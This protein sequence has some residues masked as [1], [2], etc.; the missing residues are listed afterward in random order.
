M[1]KQFDYIVVGQGIAG[2]LLSYELMRAG[3]QVLVYDL[4]QVHTPSR[5]AAGIINPISGRRFELAWKYPECYAQLEETYANL[6]SLLGQQLFFA[7][8]LYNVFPSQQMR[9]AF[10]EAST[11][12]PYMHLPT[13][14]AFSEVLHQPFGVGCVQGGNV[15]LDRL[16]Q[17]WRSK[18]ELSES[19]FDASKLEFDDLGVVYEAVR[20]RAVLFC[21]GVPMD[22]NPWFHALRFLPNK[23]EIFKI[24]MAFPEPLPFETAS[25]LKGAGITLVPL[26]DGTYWAGATFSWDYTDSKPTTEKA[27]QLQSQLQSLLRIPFEKREHLAGIRPSGPDR[28]PMVGLHPLQPKVGIFNGMG[29]KGCSLAPFA[30]R[31]FVANLLE[32]KTLDPEIDVHRFLKTLQ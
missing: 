26:E 17:G 18:L 2:S 15:A 29:S 32:G 21:D 5:L 12:S 8:T 27:L 19:Y 20:A 4:P 23:G 13:E 14:P 6:G 16:L 9:D 31:Q 24:R 25:I 22:K 10:I 3:M 28:R 30:A 11:S 1:N 7:R